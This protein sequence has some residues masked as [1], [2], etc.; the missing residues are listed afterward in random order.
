MAINYNL[1]SNDKTTF[2]L[3]RTNP[4][5]TANVKLVA[6]SNGG[7]FLSAFAA[8]KFLAQTNYQKFEL[9][10][11]G[12][13]ST[14]L[15]KF[16]NKVSAQD[17]YQ[18]LRRYS[19]TNAYSDYAFQ[20]ENQYNY[21]ATFN[22]NKIYD[23]QYKILAPIWLDRKVPEKFVIYR[24]KDTDYST[25]Y[26]DNTTGQNNRILELLKNATI[27]KT[28]DLTKQSKL[29]RYL[30]KHTFD[31]LMPVSPLKVNFD[32]N[33]E[34]EFRGIDIKNGGFAS[35][36]EFLT[37]QLVQTDYPE[38]FFN[39]LISQGFERNQIVS[40]NLI[41]LEFLF[42]DKGADNYEIY[43]YFGLYVDEI[44]EARID[45][46]ISKN[47]YV[48]INPENIE[49]LYELD[50]GIYAQ[51]MLP[52]SFDLNLPTLNY[53]KSGSGEYFHIKNN[54]HFEYLTIPVAFDS[55]DD[56]NQN[57]KKDDVVKVLNETPDTY[58]FVRLKIVEK[59]NHNDK[60]LIGDLTEIESANYDLYNFTFVADTTLVAGTFN[61]R[62]FSANGTL[63]DVTLA[64]HNA[65][66]FYQTYSK[67]N[68][69]VIK[70]YAAG[71]NRKRMVVAPHSQN[72]INFVSF[73]IAREVTLSNQFNQWVTYTTRG[74]SEVGGAKFVTLEEKGKLQIGDYIKSKDLSKYVKIVDITSDLLDD[75]KFRII[76]DKPIKASN[77]TSIQTWVRY[78]PTIGKFSA[79]DL[80]DFDFDFYSTRMSD[81]GELSLTEGGSTYF[82]NLYDVLVEESIDDS[83]SVSA[84]NSEYDRLNEN[85]L[86]E[87]AL[88]SRMVPTIMKFALKNGFNARNLPYSLNISEAFGEDNISPDLTHITG[89]NANALN[90]EHF[91]LNQIP[92]HYYTNNTLDNLQS[93]TD[94][95][96]TQGISLDQLKST[97]VNYFELYFKNNGI[98]NQFTQAWVD[99][100]EKNMFSNFIG[101]SNELEASTVFRGLRYSYKKRKEFARPNPTEFINTSEVNDY[102]FGVVLNYNT[103]DAI[104]ENGVRYT[105]IKNDK[106][107]FICI[108]IDL[109]VVLNSRSFLDREDLY[110]TN[111]IRNVITNNIIDTALPFKLF[112]GNENSQ[113]ESEIINVFSFGPGRFTEFINRNELG[114][115]S[116]IYFDYQGV[117]Y[118]MKVVNVTGDSQI[119][120]NSKP[121]K[122]VFDS[123]NEK[124]EEIG[125]ETLDDPSVVSRQTQFYYWRGGASG[126]K[127]LL[128]E[129]VANNFADRFNQFGSIQYLTITETGEQLQNRFILE[130]E[131]GVELIKPSLLDVTSDPEKPKAYQLSQSSVGSIL[132]KRTDDGYYT[133]I[134]RMNGDYTPLFNN[135]ITFTDV[136]TNHKRNIPLIGSTQIEVDS[137]ESLIYSR[138]NNLGVAFNSYKHINQSFGY[139]KNYYFHKVN[140]INSKN[141]LKLS[142]TSDKLPLYPKIGEIAI[143]KKDL[144]ILRS[145]YNQNYFTRSL[146][147]GKTED[148]Y[149]TLTPV[150]IKS[151]MASTVMKVK[152]TY[153]ITAF[154]ATLEKDINA[155]DAIRVNKLNKTSIHWIETDTQIVAD[156]YL[157]KSIYNELLEDGITSKFRKYVE[158]QY[159]YDDKTSILDDLEIYVYNN[160]VTRF[161]IDNIE[162]YGTEFK[163]GISGFESI[164]DPKLLSD[165][166]FT[167]QTNYEIQSYQNDGLSFRL[168]YNKKYGYG[169]TLKVHV[170]IQ[171]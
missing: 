46:T 136:Y 96:Y 164:V 9:S 43:R 167:S 101:G 161:I 105:T 158:A 117:T 40:A 41:N 30:H 121:I 84:I 143:D 36:S 147:T 120:V 133:I 85:E 139:I 70:D 166:G 71:N 37:K 146:P 98:Y 152:D 33:G 55:L 114:E 97:D 76:F 134:R 99:S 51:D 16:F 168:T 80:K 50:N 87:T 130:V 95:N 79:Y 75:T 14:D 112:L 125:P 159:S 108:V 3:L 62:R 34:T 48:Y 73:D 94:F 124:I 163:A 39:Q 111:N 90:M 5:L 54:T 27:V 52:S 83:T 119:Q 74:G 170:K 115:Y 19:D 122:L 8:N 142:D 49:S 69:L 18:V 92:L 28:F 113:W 104:T 86:K 107:K 67:D 17:A 126:F 155:L 35:K 12:S 38:I 140:D 91:H 118:G 13:Y 157:P 61:G 100:N 144:N 153:S 56:I 138:L 23:E 42:D 78:K 58:G 24:V 154:N 6:D 129:I 135:I 116:W 29:G 102:K 59:P 26:A 57:Y 31:K 148:A 1:N 60:I 88:L 106:F 2:S 64:L 32:L 132:T 63:V 156:F 128:E 72:F 44:P 4:K 20:Y 103:G 89:R 68:T 22:S 77:D 82:N 169:H 171:A 165:G 7:I 149:G 21:G 45:A 11:E 145:K 131:D 110:T 127:F 25:Q 162:I 137:R 151:F 109:D 150:E 47:G 15:A 141:L 10:E 81:I 65:I 160:V 53:F 66:T 93:Y 123:N